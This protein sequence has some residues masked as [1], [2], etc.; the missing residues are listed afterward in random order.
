MIDLTHFPEN[1]VTHYDKEVA[2]GTLLS[3]WANDPELRFGQFL[4][5]VLVAQNI[6]GETPAE[7][8]AQLSDKALL[9]G[10]SRMIEVHG[11]YHEAVAGYV[12]EGRAF[13]YGMKRIHMTT[14]LQAWRQIDMPL[15]HLLAASL[16]TGKHATR[17]ADMFSIEDYL[18]CWRVLAYIEAKE[19]S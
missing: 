12:P 15:A 10:A 4:F 16:M 1:A 19:Q 17:N 6:K 5:G 7:K 13:T 2:I 18:F 9:I 14:L 11:Y 8:L 3:L